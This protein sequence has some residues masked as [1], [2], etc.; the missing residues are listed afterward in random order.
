MSAQFIRMLLH[1]RG[2]LCKDVSELLCV[3]V[4]QR[5]RCGLK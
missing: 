5:A 2:A 4:D 3:H 1:G